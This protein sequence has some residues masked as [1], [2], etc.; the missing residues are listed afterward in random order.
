MDLWRINRGEEGEK[1]MALRSH[2]KQHSGKK[3]G[4]NMNT[5]LARKS[6]VS[7]AKQQLKAQGSNISPKIKGYFYTLTAIT[8]MVII[9]MILWQERKILHHQQNPPTF[10]SSP[11]PIQVN[12]LL[13]HT[14]C[15]TWFCLQGCRG[16]RQGARSGC[17]KRGVTIITIITIIFQERCQRE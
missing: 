6:S 17:F 9:R 8:I 5:M 12:H 4:Q 13:V 7:K 16:E 10:P 14:L 1:E 3:A 15:F 2:W 11:L